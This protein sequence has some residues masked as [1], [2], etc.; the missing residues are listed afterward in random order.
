M[1]DYKLSIAAFNLKKKYGMAEIT[2][3]IYADLRAAGW[4]QYDAWSVA[5]SGQGLNWPK[6]TLQANID[7]LERLESVSSRIAELQGR[8]VPKDA[9]TAEELAKATSKE[10]ILTDL[11][12]A[13]KNMKPGSKEWTETT[14]L[15]ADYN[16]IKQD[17]I[18]TE[19]STIHYYLPVNYPT[20][21]ADCLVGK[22]KKGKG[23]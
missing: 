11:V 9:L 12:I 10:Q 1:T 5:F 15:I 14:K 4:S 17:E 2:Y 22:G 3:L 19:D 6:A 20:S 13:R 8:K 23:D 7:K 21:C 18:Q 16:K